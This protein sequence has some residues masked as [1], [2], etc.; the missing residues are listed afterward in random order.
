M[1]IITYIMTSC[2]GKDFTQHFDIL[3]FTIV[4]STGYHLFFRTF[5]SNI[6]RLEIVNFLSHFK[7]FCDLV[8]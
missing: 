3:L 8:C 2:T 4:H 7:L 5:Q 1:F 6:Y